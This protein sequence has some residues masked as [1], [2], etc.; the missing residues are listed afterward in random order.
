MTAALGE[1]ARREREELVNDE[2]LA[3]LMDRIKR[4]KL[5]EGRPV[6][7]LDFLGEQRLISLTLLEGLNEMRLPLRMPTL[8]TDV[9]RRWLQIGFGVAVRRAV[10]FLWTHE[11]RL[12]AVQYRV[13]DHIIGP[14]AFPHE[15]MWWTFETA[16]GVG[17]TEHVDGILIA[18][19][20]RMEELGALR[21]GMGAGADG[22]MILTLGSED[23]RGTSAY[24]ELIG[25]LP[26]GT[27]SEVLGGGVAYLGMAA[28]LNSH[29]VDVSKKR[30]SDTDKRWHGRRVGDPSSLNVITLRS[31]VRE[32]VAVERGEGPQ[33]KQRWLVRGHLRAQWYP[34]TKSH[35]VIWIA[36][37]LKG[38]EDAP[39]KV[40][41]YRVAR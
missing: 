3:R 6:T 11:M 24:A 34:S 14:S 22:W 28:F 40:P 12:L 1:T 41:V 36:P 32:A 31:S 2:V 39:L 33:W 19:T 29:V 18:R 37:Y 20:S 13:P 30:P 10:P 4:G 7:V 9:E 5:K 26:D 27:R 35:Q 23:G 17:P 15:L 25:H 16:I 8:P 38:P 21:N